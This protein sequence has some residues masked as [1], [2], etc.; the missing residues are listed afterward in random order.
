MNAPHKFLFDRSFDLPEASPRAV[1]RK[2]PPPPPEPTFSKAEVE[3]A[4]AAGLAAGREAA[5]AEAAAAIEARAAEAATRLAE[6]VG[7]LLAQRQE[8]FDAA[9]RQA[10]EVVQSIMRKA[11]PTL[12]RKAAPA[13]IETM[14]SECLRE[15]LDEPRVVLR[16]ADALFEVLQRRLGAIT[17]ATGFA[18]KV[19]LLADETLEPGDARVEWAEGG[20]ERDIGRLMRDIDGALARALDTIPATGTS[21][22]EE[23][24][25]E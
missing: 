4:R 14:V 8:C 20:A 13:E 7:A 16:V 3:A 5:A 1:P 23:S 21:L 17:T 22:P 19:V 11:L 2:P 25:N 24:K 12:W 15:A 9:E 18:G 10:V 6:G